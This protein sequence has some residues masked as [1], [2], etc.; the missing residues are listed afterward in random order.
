MHFILLLSA[1]LAAGQAAQPPAAP[2]GP[3]APERFKDIQ[4]LTDV[5]ADQLVMTMRYFVIAT[6]IQC[7]GCHQTDASTGQL[8]PSVDSRGK[9]TARG[10]INLVKTV[11]AGNFGARINCATCHQGRNQPAG[12]PLAQAMTPEQVAQAATAR[13]RAPAGAAGGQSAGRGQPP[14]APPVADVV[15]KYIEAIGGRAAVSGLKSRIISGTVTTRMGQ[16]VPV[17][18][19]QAGDRFRSSME[20]AAPSARGFDGTAGWAK[21]GDRVSTLSGMDLMEAQAAADLMLPSQLESA[22]NLQ[23]GRSARLPGPTAGSTVTANLVQHTLSPTAT[24]RLFFDATTGLLRRRQLITRTPLNGVLTDQW[25]YSDYKA[26][27]GVQMPHTIV[28]N[29]WNTLDTMTITSVKMNAPVD[30]SR[31]AKPKQ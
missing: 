16:T 9:T 11:N 30:E 20:G 8:N 6:G 23:G 21:N 12:L 29:N 10:M 1:A 31:T 25:D 19:E 18:I 27:G 3:M 14:A 5:P 2:S 22:S 17:S 13:Q 15:A 24:E 28:F 4:V 7:N 26:E